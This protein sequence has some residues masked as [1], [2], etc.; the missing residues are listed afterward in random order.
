MHAR[1]LFSYRCR[2]RGRPLYFRYGVN[3]PLIFS[4]PPP[5]NT[6]ALKELVFPSLEKM[7]DS[8]LLFTVELKSAACER[9]QSPFIIS[10]GC[11]RLWSWPIRNLGAGTL[12]GVGVKK[13]LSSRPCWRF[14]QPLISTVFREMTCRV[15]TPWSMWPCPS[16]RRKQVCSIFTWI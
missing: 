6:T 13:I 7:R 15:P 2:P 8:S 12:S 1:R 11:T 9:E 4:P 3:F 14:S 16:L 10:W 5:T